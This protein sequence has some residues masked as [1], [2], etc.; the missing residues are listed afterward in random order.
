MEVIPEAWWNIDSKVLRRL[1]KEGDEVEIIESIG[2]VKLFFNFFHLFY[3]RI[4]NFFKFVAIIEL[5]S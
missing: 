4:P 5:I 2:Y 1:L 3:Y